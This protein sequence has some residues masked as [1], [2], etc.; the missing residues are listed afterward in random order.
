MLSSQLIDIDETG[1]YLKDCSRNYGLGHTSWHVRY[2]CQYKRNEP[3][4]NLIMAINPGNPNVD[5]NLDGSINRPRRWVTITKQNYDQ[6]IF[7]DF[8]NMILRDIEVYS[9]AGDETCCL[10]RDNLIMY[11]TAY[12]T[13]T[14]QDRASPNNFFS[15]DRPPY[16]PKMAPIEYIFCEGVVL[17][18][19]LSRETG[20]LKIFVVRSSIS[21]S[22]SIVTV[23]LTPHLSTVDILFS[24][25]Y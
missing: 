10:M 6:W 21:S 20:V 15:A 22:T 8:V 1:F 11:K 24:I 19:S 23:D 14:I 4:L 12:V 18:K 7:A 3:K 5:P 9:G 25:V 16:Q 13:T 2:L 17:W